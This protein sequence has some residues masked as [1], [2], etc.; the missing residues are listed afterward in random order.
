[1]EQKW[2]NGVNGEIDAR[3]GITSAVVKFYMYTWSEEEGE[4]NRL[5]VTGC[6]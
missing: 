5:V 2:R 6:T 3:V 4:N 1:M